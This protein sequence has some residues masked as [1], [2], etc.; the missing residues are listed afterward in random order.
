MRGAL[1]SPIQP[2]S[3]TV[4]VDA[5]RCDK[6]V[7]QPCR[8]K[9]VPHDVGY[10]LEQLELMALVA[11]G[12]ECDH[13]LDGRTT[14]HEATHLRDQYRRLLREVETLARPLPH[15]IER[16]DMLRSFMMGAQH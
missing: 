8:G 14:G 3:T 12:P 10:W 15:P 16:R 7:L 9:I 13:R 4:A 11:F 2:A 5:V 6:R 1:Q